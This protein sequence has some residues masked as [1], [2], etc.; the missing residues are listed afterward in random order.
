MIDASKYLDPARPVRRSI[1]AALIIGGA[2]A[3]ALIGLVLTPLGKIVAGA[4]PADVANYLWNAGV[5]GVMGAAV[6]PLVV[7]SSLRHV[8]LWRTIVEPL[9][10]ASIGATAA[11]LLASGPA[12]LV[13]TPLG[14]VA[15]AARLAL[16]ARRRPGLARHRTA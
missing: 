2:V 15:A 16:S 14:A 10:G 3:G 6:A 13:L 1:T 12:L 5:F 7:W 9:A 4:P 8:P 11:W